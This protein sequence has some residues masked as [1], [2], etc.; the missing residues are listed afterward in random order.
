LSLLDE[1]PVGRKTIKTWVVPEQK[2]LDAYKWIEAQKTQSFIICPLIE[3]SEAETML[4]VKAAKAEF[5]YLSKEVFSKLKLGLIHGRLKPKEKDNVLNSFKDK[6]LDILVA[7]PVVEVG[8]DIP[9]ATIMI[10]EAAERFGLAQLH[11][12]RGRVGRGEAQSYCLLFTTDSNSIARLKYL[13]TI[14]NGLQLAE[15]D[16]RFRG[17]GQRYGTAQH[18]KWDLK[19]ASFDNLELVE[20]TNQLAQKVLSNPHQFPLLLALLQQSKIHVASN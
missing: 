1:M 13:E 19:I 2:R 12:L 8:I 11:Q 7:T 3:E 5:D 20:K 16:L 14:N 17:P 4:E 6:K 15:T 18:G 10:I 9:S